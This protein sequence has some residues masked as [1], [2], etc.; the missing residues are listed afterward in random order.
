MSTEHELR[1]VSY[2]QVVSCLESLFLEL[3]AVSFLMKLEY[4][5][6]KS[7]DWSEN[8]GIVSHELRT[9][10]TPGYSVEPASEYGYF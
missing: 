1:P 7:S 6:L 3:H 2:T 10:S 9:P 4:G 8:G 5:Y